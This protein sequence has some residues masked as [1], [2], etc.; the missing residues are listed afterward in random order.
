MN[1]HELLNSFLSF[2]GDLSHDI[3]EFRIILI[4]SVLGFNVKRYTARPR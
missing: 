3:V 4:L 2:A 1:F